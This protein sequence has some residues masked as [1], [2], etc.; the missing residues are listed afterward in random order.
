M[1]EY[2]INSQFTL[3]ERAKQCGPGGK[4]ILPVLDVMDK[5]GVPAFL[6]DV[7][8]FPASHGLKNRITRTAGRTSPTRRRFYQGVERTSAP[9]QVLWDDVVLFEERTEI[10]EDHVDTLENGDVLRGNEDR[11]KAAAILEGVC[12]AFFN[13]RITSGG[14]YIEGF[15]GRMNTLSYPGGSTTTLPYCWNQGGSSTL[16]SI[17]CIDWGPMACHGFYPSVTGGKMGTLGVDIRNKGKEPKADTDSS[18]ATYYVY[19]TQLKKW[20]GLSMHDDRRWFRIANVNCTYGG[21]NGFDETT[22][23]RALNHSRIRKGT[24]SA[25]IYVNAYIQSQIDILA[26]K[27]GNVN[28]TME[29]VFGEP[30]QTFLKIPIRVL[31]ETIL[32]ASETAVT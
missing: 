1:A 16:G 18:T 30:V 3:L 25:R 8:Y 10:D 28:L 27:K 13:D 14:E 12:N 2:N 11:E 26:E 7:P 6:K 29:N 32:T 22:L 9:T 19:V 23:I 31:D 17:Y 20:V 24:G 5:L 15:L 4:K 21:S